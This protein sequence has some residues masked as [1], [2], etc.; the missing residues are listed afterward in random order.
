MA[1]RLYAN[2]L[3]PFVRKVRI[4]FVREGGRVRHRRDRARITA[5][6][7]LPINP[8]GEVP[9]LVDGETVVAGSALICDYLEERFPEPALMPAAPSA[10]ARCR[11]LEHA[12]DTHTDALQFLCFLFAVRRPELR[13]QYPEAARAL[14]VAV[15]Q[16]YL[17]LERELGGRDCFVG[18]FSRADL[19]LVP[20]LTSLAYLGEPIPDGCGGLRG[21]LDRMRRRPSVARDAAQALA[22]WE[23]AA[24]SAD[25]FFRADRIHW[26]GERVEWA[27]RLGLGTWLAGEIEAGRAY[28]SPP[29]GDV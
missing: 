13:D 24:T 29:A 12:A 3:S 7:A 19:A 4:T 6:R 18:A 16:H 8:R 26:R 27:V 25:P 15:H 23:R 11:T 9:A 1:L 17:I 10:R 21:W 14:S 5:G 28:F 2:S 22:A 20:H